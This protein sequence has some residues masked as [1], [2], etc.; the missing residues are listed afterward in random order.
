MA[1]EKFTTNLE[2]TTIYTLKC[3]AAKHKVSVNEIIEAILYQFAVSTEDYN[4]SLVLK[5]IWTD[6]VITI[7]NAIERYSEFKESCK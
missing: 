1:K 3:I 6:E 4:T 2:S 7:E 5:T